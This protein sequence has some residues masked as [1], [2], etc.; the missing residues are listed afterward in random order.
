MIPEN[1]GKEALKY[2]IVLFTGKDDL[3][4]KSVE[5]FVSENTCLQQVVHDCGGRY[6]A[7][8]NRGGSH[9][10]V[11]ELFSKIENMLQINKADYYTKDMYKRTQ[12][13]NDQREKET[14]TNLEI[15]EN[16]YKKHIERELL[17]NV[18]EWVGE[19]KGEPTCSLQ[20]EAAVAVGAYL[21][22]VGVGVGVG[23]GCK[24]GPSGAFTGGAI[25]GITGGVVG[26]VL[27]YKYGPKVV[28]YLED[29]VIVALNERYVDSAEKDKTV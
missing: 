20:M 6:H 26:G 12:K 18:K 1:F 29:A 3:D 7:F 19:M 28:D 2:T 8:N 25:G 11:T 24:A 5:K 15:K 27:G 23:V 14:K 17:K 13:I 10:Q 21:G 4:G 9:R 16:Q 22:V